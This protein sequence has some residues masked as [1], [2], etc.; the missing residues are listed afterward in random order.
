MSA[1]KITTA[2][3]ADEPAWRRLWDGFL[4]H[5]ALTL[6]EST[7]A[8]TWARII[9][10]DH[11]M[12]CRLAWLDGQ[13]QGFAIHHHHC[14]SWVPGDDLYLEDL[15]V[16]PQA[17][18]AGLGRALIEDLIAIGRAKGFHRLYWN[19]D[20]DNTAARWLYDQFCRDDG[21]IRYRLTL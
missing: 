9:D 4:D 5:Y 17:R 10:P 8:A 15:F 6:P 12:S 20:R 19:T 7:T 13:P 18:G 2:T 16:A 3:P 11:R 1:P 14:S 21:H